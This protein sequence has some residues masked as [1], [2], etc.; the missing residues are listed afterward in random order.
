MQVHHLTEGLVNRRFCESV[1]PSQVRTTDYERMRVKL[2]KK[3][4]WTEQM[5]LAW[6]HQQQLVRMQ[7]D[8][9]QFAMGN[10]GNLSANSFQAPFSTDANGM[11]NLPQIPPLPTMSMPTMSMPLSLSLPNVPSLPPLP[12]L[13]ASE[14]PATSVSNKMLWFDSAPFPN[15]SPNDPNSFVSNLNSYG[16]IR[17]NTKDN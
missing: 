7:Q 15:I 12:Q 9:L 16:P 1:V 17:T 11:P 8:Q 10:L 4:V 6:Q 14:I 5:E 13:P 2:M 3:Q